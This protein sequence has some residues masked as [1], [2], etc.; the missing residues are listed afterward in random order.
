M[1]NDNKKRIVNVTDDSREN[2]VHIK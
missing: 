2:M 1:S